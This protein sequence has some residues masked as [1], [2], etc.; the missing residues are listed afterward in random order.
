MQMRPAPISVVIPCYQCADTIQRAVESIAR[1]TLVPAEVLL[2]DDQSND[3]TLERLQHLRDMHEAGW[4]RVLS[5]GSNGGPS[6]ARNTGWNAASQPY[7]AFLD[8]DDSWHPQKI[9][10]QYGWM[11]AHPEVA[12]SG[13]RFSLKRDLA[14]PEAVP[15]PVEATSFSRRELLLSNRFSTPTVMLRRSIVNRFEEAKRHSEDF[16][17]WL[18]IC[19]EG[20]PFASLSADLTYLHKAPYGEGGLSSELGAM[21]RGE[22]DTYARLFRKGYISRAEYAFL[23][24]WCRLKHLRR[25]ALQSVSAAPRWVPGSQGRSAAALDQAK[26]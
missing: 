2:V 5:S 12:L 11:A 1:Q 6:V 19:L 26:R 7:I 9:E 8:A 23:R 15:C 10:I 25:L 18:E 24:C 17:L 14:P 21:T 20:Q 4:I 13:H 16:L 3:G 22:L